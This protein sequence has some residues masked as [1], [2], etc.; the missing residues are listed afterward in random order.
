LELP[1]ILVEEDSVDG[2]LFVGAYLNDALIQVVD[3]NAT[4]IV[5]VDAYATSNGYDAI[6]SDNFAG[7]YQVVTYLIQH[8]HRHIGLVGGSHAQA[9]PSIQERRRGYLQA[10]EDNDIATPYLADCHIINIEEVTE[11]TTTLLQHHPEITAIFGVNDEVALTVMGL[12]QELGRQVPDDLSVVGFDNIDLASCVFPP[13][14]TMHV[15][16]L[17]MGRLAVQLLV[18]RAE[19]PDASPVRATLRPRLVERRSVA[20]LQNF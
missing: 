7:A 12:A 8:G 16:K 3:R 20:R 1:R 18:N 17:G 4:S 11:A 10:L 19:H 9:Y 13:L 15:D 2:L 6:L 14:T 5:L